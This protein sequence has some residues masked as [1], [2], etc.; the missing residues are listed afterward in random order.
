MIKVITERQLTVDLNYLDLIATGTIQ[1]FK[2]WVKDKKVIGCDTESEM[3]IS[4]FNKVLSMQI[5]DVETQWMFDFNSLLPFQIEAIADVMANKEIVKI[6]HNAKYDINVLRRSGIPEQH[7]YF[8]TQL[9]EQVYDSGLTRTKGW[10]QLAS[11]LSRYYGVAVDKTFRTKFTYENILDV[12]SILYACGDVKYLIPLRRMQLDRLIAEGSAKE[13]CQDLY[14]VLGLE[15]R[16]VFGF[17]EMEYHGIRVK[18]SKL[19]PLKLKIDT[20]VE[21]IIEELNQIVL[22]DN[23][24]SKH[25]KTVPDLFGESFSFSWTSSQQKLEMLKRIFPNIKSTAKDVLAAYAGQHII[26]D[27]LLEFSDWNSLK[28]K[29]INSIPKHINKETGNIHPSIWQILSTGRISMARPNLQQVSSKHELA[30]ELRAIFVPEPGEIFN[31]SDYS[32][33]ELRLIA[34]HSQD[35]VWLGVL[36]ANGDL[37]SEL[38]VKTFKITL[39]KVKEQSPYGDTWRGV[40]KTLNFGLAYGMGP[41]KLAKKLGI[42]VSA[43]QKIIDD[44]FAACP[45]VKEFLD[46][47]GD[48]G[49]ERRYV[50]TG[51]PY[52]R[53]R[54]F[55]GWDPKWPDFRIKKIQESIRRKAMNFPFQGGNAN[56]VKLAIVYIIERREAH[57]LKDL[58]LRLQIHDELISS[59]PIKLGTESLTFIEDTMMEAGRVCVPSVPMICEP[60]LSEVWTK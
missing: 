2:Q 46:M 44:F 25:Y 3:G 1:E 9:A 51:Q 21:K 56:I 16:S 60:K 43:A 48:L 53:I 17:A 38:C 54:K 8:C 52:G 6:W 58:K 50:R 41:H 11:L 49:V 39:D 45:A 15:N 34:D 30:M 40:Q 20:R 19:V 28:T 24:L 42:S 37:H 35:P 33:C 10:L 23:I 57:G 59:V 5:G 26:I 12:R 18:L 14:T 4:Q 29:F 36:N 32:G 55:D 13:D 22:T 7:N 31:I 47:I 27:K